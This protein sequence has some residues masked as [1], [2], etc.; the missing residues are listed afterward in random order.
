[1]ELVELGKLCTLIEERVEPKNLTC[2]E[3]ALYSIPAWMEYRPEIV[4]PISIKSSKFLL[5]KE[6]ILVSR[7]NPSTHRVWRIFPEEFEGVRL[8]STEWAVILPN[9][10][11]SLPYIHCCLEQPA[12]KYQLEAYVTGTTNSHQRVRRGDFLKLKIPLLPPNIEFS[13]GNLHSLTAGYRKNSKQSE[14]DTNSIISAI[15][16]SWFIDFEP[17]RLKTNGEVPYGMDKET[18]DLFPD[19]FSDTN[20]GMIPQGWESM[21]LRDILFTKGKTPNRNASGKDMLDIIDM[22]LIKHGIKKRTSIVNS[23]IARKRD[24]LMLMDGE[25]SGFIA[26]SPI[27]GA[28]GSTFAIVEHDL[29]DRNFLFELLRSNEYWIRRNVTG[30]GIPHA[31]KEIVRRIEFALPPEEIRE[32]FFMTVEVLLTNT[33]QSQEAASSLSNAHDSVVSRFMNGSP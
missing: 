17:V 7:L 33:S 23:V 15:F 31:D 32:K 10:L 1:M 25:N 14:I 27:E 19:S 13:L 30:T 11:S 16:K 28:V 6:A 29:L 3:V 26:R 20:S 24:V 21:D 9:E 22:D 12:F 4:N 2:D 8:G 5:P 18:A